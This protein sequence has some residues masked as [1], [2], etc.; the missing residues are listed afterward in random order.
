MSHDRSSTGH[1]AIAHTVRK[2]LCRKTSD[3]HLIED[4][5]Q[6][7]LLACWKKE[8]ALRGLPPERF[9]RFVV[10]VTLNRY[11]SELRQ[12]RLLRLPEGFE[13]VSKEEDPAWAAET[14][15]QEL[16]LLSLID[17]LPARYRQVVRLHI[18]EGWTYARIARD[19]NLS[20]NTI[21][22][23]FRRAKA[24]LVGRVRRCFVN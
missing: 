18:V 13:D 10:R 17:G 24:I 16:C 2:A 23:Q 15:E 12:R 11:Y 9:D 3:M 7:V 14:R 19:K 1:D 6:N 21:K 20:V 5:C 8:N 4:V 22:T